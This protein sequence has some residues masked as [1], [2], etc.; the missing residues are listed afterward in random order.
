MRSI[1]R[2]PA[3][4]KHS[5]VEP[6]AEPLPPLPMPE[7]SDQILER[8]EPCYRQ[9]LQSMQAQ[10]FGLLSNDRIAIA[11][12]DA[13]RELPSRGRTFAQ[14]AIDPDRLFGI[15]PK[16]RR[17]GD[18]L[19]SNKLRFGHDAGAALPVECAGAG[20]FFRLNGGELLTVC[21][22]YATFTRSDVAIIRFQF[23]L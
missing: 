22:E 4:H 9:G 11:L 8:I 12:S 21:Q 2:Q 19:A 16:P 7:I 15:R 23:D 18:N 10:A 3:P 6:K 1:T 20:L 13:I 17:L 14:L 5:Y